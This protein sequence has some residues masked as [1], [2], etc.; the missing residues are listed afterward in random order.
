MLCLQRLEVFVAFLYS[1][2][3]QYRYVVLE[4]KGFRHLFI[5]ILKLW[6]TH[7]FHP[8]WLI[9]HILHQLFEIERPKGHWS[10]V[11]VHL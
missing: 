8:D 6:H 4:K 10:E 7:M 9:L 5:F 2:S 11:M 1:L 3:I